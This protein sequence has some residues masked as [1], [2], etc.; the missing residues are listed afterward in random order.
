MTGK[1]LEL[2]AADQVTDEIVTA[3]YDIADGW[4]RDTGI[5][6]EDLLDRLDGMETADGLILD[7]GDSL[8]SPAIREIR[9]RVRKM[10]AES[11]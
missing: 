11:D 3:A 5:D 6:W 9:K 8:L 2:R 7:L 1:Y 10:L 4:Y